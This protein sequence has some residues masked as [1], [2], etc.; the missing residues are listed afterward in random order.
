M[1]HEARSNIDGFTFHITG[2]RNFRIVSLASWDDGFTFH[3]TGIVGTLLIGWYDERGSSIC[4][5][6]T[7]PVI[8]SAHSPQNSSKFK[9]LDHWIVTHA[10]HIIH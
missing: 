2:M 5:P 9:V 6:P 3:I 10:H 8:V 7:R 1:D 4:I